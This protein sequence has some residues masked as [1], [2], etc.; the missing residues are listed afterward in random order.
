VPSCT[1]FRYLTSLNASDLTDASI[2]TVVIK[3][4]HTVAGLSMRTLEAQ[5][6]FR[7]QEAMEAFWNSD[8]SIS[9]M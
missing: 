1:I 6:E 9:R 5:A 4:G 8:D 2:I 7:V 3:A